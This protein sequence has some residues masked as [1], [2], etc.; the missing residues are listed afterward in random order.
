M[1]T[2]RRL[3]C[4]ALVAAGIAA[5]A[6]CGGDDPPAVTVNEAQPATAKPAPAPPA[7][8]PA[9][10]PPQSATTPAPEGAPPT[11]APPSAAEASAPAPVAAT[12]ES[13]VLATEAHEIPGVQ[14]ALTEL[15]RTSGDT[16]TLRLQFRNTTN[17]EVSDSLFYG[18]NIALRTY[19]LDATRKKYTVLQDPD[20]RP[21]GY[22]GQSSTISPGGAVPAWVRFP[23]PP[24]DVTTVT[25]VVPG[26]P[27][28]D[29]IPVR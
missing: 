12:G 11:P 17:K 15:R 29:G 2:S 24:A 20:N 8:T 25:V 18:T 26:V 27:P 5:S 9:A 16:V 22:V 23:A 3:F 10:P 6:A 1:Y 28:F 7:A 4:V 13:G 14:V 21:V 19:L